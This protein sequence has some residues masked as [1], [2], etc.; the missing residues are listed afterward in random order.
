MHWPSP[1]QS[2]HCCLEAEDGNIGIA[3][4]SPPQPRVKA[5]PPAA[6]QNIALGPTRATGFLGLGDEPAFAEEPEQK[7]AGGRNSGMSKV[8]LKSET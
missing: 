2:S 8:F 6:P 7:R 1:G 5:V 3:I 4:F